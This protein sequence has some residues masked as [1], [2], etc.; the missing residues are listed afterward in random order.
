VRE[1]KSSQPQLGVIG[2][3]NGKNNLLGT[4]RKNNG[5]RCQH[6]QDSD[7]IVNPVAHGGSPNPFTFQR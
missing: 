2:R 3:I 4:S 6:Q 1:I 5:N 7:D